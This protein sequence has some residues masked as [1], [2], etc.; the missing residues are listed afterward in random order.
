MSSLAFLSADA[1]GAPAAVSP[2][3]REAAAA[4]ARFETR[5]GWE[6]AISYA[7]LK[8]E[9]Q[10]IRETVGFADVS[11]LGVLELQGDLS[12]VEGVALQCGTAVRHDD[13]WWCAATPERA[14]V[15]CAPSATASLRDALAASFKGHVLD[16]TSGFAAV[17]IAGPLA[18]E[19]FAR[20]CALDLRPTVTPV[21]GFRPGSVARTPGYVLRE[22]PDRYLALVGA[23]VGSYVWEVVADAATHLG[24]R[25]VGVDALAEAAP[26]AATAEEVGTHA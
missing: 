10:A 4:G 24:G 17:A 11:H 21:A 3:A 22:G 7:G 5:D 25:P 18:R 23:A 19:T 8:V 13:A 16:M 2:M 9:Q 20:F 14:F 12:S 6:V 26:V 15:I 1:P